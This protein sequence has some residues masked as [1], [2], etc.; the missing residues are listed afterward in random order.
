MLLAVSILSILVA[1]FFSYRSS[2]AALTKA[3]N[4]KLVAIREAT[5]RQITATFTGLRRSLVLNSINDTAIEAM[6]S[7]DRDFDALR[8]AT[9]TPAEQ[10]GV[11]KYYQD[12][13]VPGLKENV[14]GDI[15]VASFEPNT[16]AQRYL[17]AKYTA[18]HSSFDDAI[19]VDDAGDGSAWSADHAKYHNFFR[20]VVQQNDYEDAMLVDPDGNI[21]Y[22]SYKGTDLGAS[23]NGAPYR[24]SK[25]SAAFHQVLRTNAVNSV[26]LVDYEP[27]TPSYDVPTAFGLSP[28]GKDGK[29]IG[30]LIIQLPVPTINNL[31][32]FGGKWEQAGL[33]RT[34]EALLVGPDSTLRS[35]SRDLLADPQHY[36]DQVVA[37]GTPADVADRIVR[38]NNPIL[39]QPITSQAATLARRGESGIIT[40]NSYL[41][42][43][44][45]KAYAP[46]AVSDTV[47]WAIIVQI[48]EDE[49]LQPVSDLLRTLALSTLAVVLVVTLASVLMA[50][51][52]SRPVGQLL[53]G[54]RKVAAGD[55]SARVNLKAAGEFG[56][57]A[58]AFNDMGES[59]STKQDLLDAQMTENDR[60][61]AN[62][63]PESVARRYREG[64][65]N[66]VDEHQDVSV[67]FA[68][69]DGLDELSRRT[70][71]A[72]A[73]A[74]LNELVQGFDLA[75]ERVGVEKVR[76]LRSGYIAS[77][78][79]ATQRIDHAVRIVEFAEAMESVVHAFGARNGVALTLRVGI[80]SGSVTSGLVGASAVYD[81]WGDSV[82]LAYRVR[83]AG[84]E[85]GI[86]VSQAVYEKVRDTDT[87]EAAG[88][89]TGKDG[90]QQ[91]WRL[92]DGRVNV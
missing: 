27:Y 45:L 66:I 71:T 29:L 90:E 9:V 8:S 35:T 65:S 14:Q 63:M 83:N 10:A 41:G 38:L 69:V 73:M 52:F 86:Y 11:D 70:T 19:K 60:M 21:V 50:R 39:A 18:P 56:D 80:D 24:N 54:V 33:G 5:S 20:E 28:I 23:L 30:V 87:F 2:S 92:T 51:S 13:F 55:L 91:I 77:C 25:L 68:T 57:L 44:T 79:L 74:Q 12:V 76:T 1:G 3:A 48:D 32:T 61:L 58:D 17:Q 59:L 42:R 37:A 6:S 15:D 4:D 47:N 85:P 81:M 40:E 89:V 72:E 16:A 67:L 88:T 46:L 7:F 43:T 22:T 53:T 64:E 78:G 34:G 75:A 62:L 31:M 84:A 82:N 36:R 49:A 26:A